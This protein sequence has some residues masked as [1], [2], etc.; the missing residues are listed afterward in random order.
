MKTSS[1]SLLFACWITAMIATLGSLFFSQVMEFTPCV[2]CW[3]QR[4][5]MYP[6]VIIFLVGALKAPESTFVFSA[7]L[8]CIGWLIA[9]YHNLLHYEVVPESASPCLEGVSCST[10]YIEWFGFITIP[11]LSLFAFT[12]I[13]ILLI[14]FKR[15]I[16]DEK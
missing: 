15:T 14:Y 4:I 2:L 3:Y 16:I 1:F 11:I 7:P 12:L 5:V 13:G 9:L 8:V 6:L 10:V